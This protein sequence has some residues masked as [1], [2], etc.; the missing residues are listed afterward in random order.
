MSSS[1]L[2]K[3][4]LETGVMFTEKPTSTIGIG[5]TKV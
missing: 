5:R 3:D 4:L 1:L 2:I